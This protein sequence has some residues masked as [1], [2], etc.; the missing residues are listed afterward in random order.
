MI[1][2]F[3]QIHNLRFI[4]FF[5]SHPFV[6]AMDF[7]ISDIREDCKTTITNIL[8]SLRG[9]KYVFYDPQLTLHFDYL[10]QDPLGAT[11]LKECSVIDLK[12]LKSDDREAIVDTPSQISAPDFVMYIVYP[13]SAVIK[14]VARITQLYR[15]SGATIL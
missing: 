13:N 10:L 4:C 9:R 7:S 1:E 3:L 2:S 11:T 14:S 6:I 15:D 5:L 12:E 8:R